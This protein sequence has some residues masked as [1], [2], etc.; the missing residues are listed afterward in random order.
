MA[1]FSSAAFACALI[2][3]NLGR[4]DVDGNGG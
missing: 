2:Q 4:A 3:T 1:R